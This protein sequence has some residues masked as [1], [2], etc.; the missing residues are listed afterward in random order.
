MQISVW[1]CSTI[2]S[3]FSQAAVINCNPTYRHDETRSRRTRYYYVRD[4]AILFLILQ[5]D[6]NVQ[7]LLVSRS[8]LTTGAAAAPDCFDKQEQRQ[9]STLPELYEFILQPLVKAKLL[10]YVRYSRKEAIRVTLLFLGLEM[11]AGYG[12]TIGT[13]H[14]VARR[15][16]G[17]VQSGIRTICYGGPRIIGSTDA[18]ASSLWKNASGLI[19]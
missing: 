5:N 14:D 2:I 10:E 9:L 7:A 4:L 17:G 12:D 11:T 18:H 3:I 6:E 19:K 13:G 1:L 16:D 15:R 8:T